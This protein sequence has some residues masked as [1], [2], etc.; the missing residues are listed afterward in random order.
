MVIALDVH[1]AEVGRT[2]LKPSMIESTALM[3]RHVGAELRHCG[4]K[5]REDTA[6]L[7]LRVGWPSDGKRIKRR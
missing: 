5:L 4:L 7:R 6:E 1:L 3:V 2:V